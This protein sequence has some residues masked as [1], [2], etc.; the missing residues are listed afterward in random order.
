VVVYQASAVGGGADVAASAQ[1]L[2]AY[3]DSGGSCIPTG[4]VVTL[5]VHSIRVVHALTWRS[6]IVGA[7]VL[8]GA[9][10][11]IPTYLAGDDIYVAAWRSGDWLSDPSGYTVVV[12]A[13]A[14]NYY[15]TMWRKT[16]ASGSSWDVVTVT[17]A[18]YIGVWVV[19]GSSGVGASAVNVASTTY[20]G[21]TLQQ[22]GGSSWVMSMG[23]GHDLHA[24][25]PP[26]G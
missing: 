22:S 18:S 1:R 25:D 20:P 23:H 15:A 6:L 13:T 9:S 19:R 7:N 16:A 10:A 26:P 21:L 8:S 4:A 2:I 5:A 14:S 3:V 17:G 12:G 24:R 11:A